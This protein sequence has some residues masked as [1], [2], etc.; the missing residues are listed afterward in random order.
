[1]P[2][3]PIDIRYL[4]SP[5]VAD[6]AP[7]RSDCIPSPRTHRA[8]PRSSDLRL[9]CEELTSLSRAP[10]NP[11]LDIAMRSAQRVRPILV[12]RRAGAVA[13]AE[14]ISATASSIVADT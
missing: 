1:L 12:K 2:D 14:A 3:R 8:L 4:I 9:A 6:G 10:G 7:Q 13:I 5:S 11:I